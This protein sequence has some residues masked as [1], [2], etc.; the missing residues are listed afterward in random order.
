M[1]GRLATE[2]KEAITKDDFVE[3]Y[4]NIYA[5]IEV[6][7]LKIQTNPPEDLEPDENGEVRIPFELSMETLAGP[8]TFSLKGHSSRK[9]REERVGL[10]CQ[11]G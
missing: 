9:S 4:E 11:M 3:R 10:V 2:S 1:Y 6:H 8:V 5:G 7:N